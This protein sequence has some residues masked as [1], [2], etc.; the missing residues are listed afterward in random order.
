MSNPYK[1][2]YADTNPVFFDVAKTNAADMDGVDCRFIFAWGDR[3]E[4]A[5][6][7]GSFDLVITGGVLNDKVHA[8]VANHPRK[9]P[10]HIIMLDDPVQPFTAPGLAV[11]GRWKFGFESVVT[12]A[13]NG[14]WQTLTTP[15]PP[16]YIPPKIEPTPTEIGRAH[17]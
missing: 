13:R 1:I 8:A 16:L 5:L 6:D 2:L 11:L 3:V 4:R 10:N 17:V 9:P 7:E 14:D 15:P 12:L